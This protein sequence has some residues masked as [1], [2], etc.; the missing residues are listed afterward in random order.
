MELVELWVFIFDRVRVLRKW[1]PG[2]GK[3]GVVGGEWEDR[4]GRWWWRRV[5]KVE[6]GWVGRGA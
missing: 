6:G 1:V 5:V 3:V 4:G 2:D